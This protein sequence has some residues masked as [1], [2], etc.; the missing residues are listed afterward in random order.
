MGLDYTDGKR[1]G[2]LARQLLESCLQT[3][4][5]SGKRRNIHKCDINLH[6]LDCRYAIPDDSKLTYA[7][8]AA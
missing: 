6:V 3:T 4:D 1:V 2:I 8:R 7:S 5:G